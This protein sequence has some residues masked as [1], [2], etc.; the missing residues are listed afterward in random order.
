MKFLKDSKYLFLLFIILA[1][2]F[3]Q[4]A[5]FLS[6]LIFPIVIVVTTLNIYDA[7]FHS[8]GRENIKLIIKLLAIN[9]LLLGG[10]LILSSIIFIDDSSLKAGLILL[11]V[12]PPAMAIIPLTHLL[13]SDTHDG[14]LADYIGYLIAIILVPLVTL[15]FIGG[16]FGPFA[17]IQ[18]IIALILMPMIFSKLIINKKI[19]CVEETGNILY[20]LIVYILVGLSVPTLLSNFAA[21][22]PILVILI[23][24][25]FVLGGG[26]YV[27]LISK[28]V[29]EETDILYVLFAT[30]KNGGVASVLAIVLFGGATIVPIGISVL[31]LPFYIAFLQIIIH[32]HH[33]HV[34]N[35]KHGHLKHGRLNIHK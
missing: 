14:A 33:M 16:K 31:L 24:T 10:L 1:F 27:L 6:I 15:I 26:I 17:V 23:V 4:G 34:R 21:V 20:G 22:A 19:N 29:K 8:V 3:P 11:G 18:M 25:T 12:A 35:H 30:L 32:N 7:K 5:K 2:L 9:Y 28:H 13:K